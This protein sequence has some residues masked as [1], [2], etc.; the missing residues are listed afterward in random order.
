MA[1]MD[2]FKQAPWMGGFVQYAD[3]IPPGPHVYG[4]PPFGIWPTSF[5]RPVPANGA[6]IPPS[7]EEEARKK[8]IQ[9]EWDREKALFIEKKRKQVGQMVPVQPPPPS[10]VTEAA[11]KDAAM[12]LMPKKVDMTMLWG[13]IAVALL[14]LGTR[15][16]AEE[17][18]ATQ[19]LASAAAIVGGAGLV[20]K[21]L[22]VS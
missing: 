22:Q 21:A 7:S 16:M 19:T 15:I 5:R 3:P 17:K 1:G 10:P 6:P 4:P 8:D 20:Y 18:T 14:G 13:G 9:R 11:A 2:M 12:S